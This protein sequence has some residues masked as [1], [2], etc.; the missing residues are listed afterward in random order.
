MLGHERGRIEAHGPVPVAHEAR[1]LEILPN[2]FVTLCRDVRECGRRMADLHESRRERMLDAT[3]EH[4]ARHHVRLDRAGRT[5]EARQN[6]AVRAV[7]I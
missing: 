1:P 4:P 7:A 2:R 5:N 3:L 6:L